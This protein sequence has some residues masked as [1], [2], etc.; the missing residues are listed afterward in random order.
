VTASEE[1]GDPADNRAADPGATSEAG[2]LRPT[3]GGYYSAERARATDWFKA[4]KQAKVVV[5][6][7]LDIDE[8]L[9]AIASLD[10]TLQKT[11]QLAEARE[12]PVAVH[13]WI[14]RL[15]STHLG[16]LI[17]NAAG[18]LVSDASRIGRLLKA[19]GFDL[20]AKDQDRRRYAENLLRLAIGQHLEGRGHLLGAVLLSLDEGLTRPV[21]GRDR[22]YAR[23]VEE[24]LRKGSIFSI[25]TM[26]ATYAFAHE[27]AEGLRSERDRLRV[28]NGRQ[29]RLLDKRQMEVDRLARCQAEAEQKI[30]EL[31]AQ[32]ADVQRRHAERTQVAHHGAAELRT[33]VR[34]FLQGR[35]Q[36]LLSDA[37]DGVEIAVSEIG[38]T[39][40]ALGVAADRLRAAQ[41]ALGEEIEWLQSSG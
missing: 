20:R 34:T 28:D 30:A 35:L 32:I 10:P 41:A 6:T 18:G 9:N 11:V 8:T 16:V 2:E 39:S 27:Q 26:A 3:L 21:T 1:T 37:V 25:A 17:G 33:D 4:L 15:L 22:N 14:E 24:K 7:P 38:P 12:A 13:R 19:S 31:T 5:F 23:E 36:P 29:E 40:V